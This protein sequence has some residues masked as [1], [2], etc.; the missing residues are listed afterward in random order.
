M[1]EKYNKLDKVEMGVWEALE[2]LDTL[3]DNSD[4]TIIR[5][6]RRASLT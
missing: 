1:E 4:V 6:P 5:V 2:Y 3:V